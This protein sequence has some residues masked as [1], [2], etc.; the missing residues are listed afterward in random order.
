MLS[1]Y[2][3]TD[4]QTIMLLEM[5]RS[6][7]LSEA[8]LQRRAAPRP[9]LPDVMTSRFASAASAG[10]LRKALPVEP[11]LAVE[12]VGVRGT[13]VETYIVPR[14]LLCLSPGLK[15]LLDCSTA[16]YRNDFKLKRH[17]P[18][19]KKIERSTRRFN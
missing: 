3:R 6:S 13:Q 4:Y 15:V 2:F 7:L 18:A 11:V 12:D 9:K 8:P 17:S 19:A 14:Y 16:S 1:M 10:N 5:K